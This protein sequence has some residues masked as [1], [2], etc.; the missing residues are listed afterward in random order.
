MT[1]LEI[2]GHQL[3]LELYILEKEGY[4]YRYN[5][6]KGKYMLNEEA[7]LVYRQSS[8]YPL[9]NLSTVLG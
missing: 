7:N 9:L 8:K 3:N 2:I 4:V 1:A 6:C 5:P